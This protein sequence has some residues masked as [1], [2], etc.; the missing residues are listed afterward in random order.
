MDDPGAARLGACGVKILL[1]W[2]SG[3]DSAW[4]LHLLNQQHP[5]AVQGL[6]TTVNESVDRVA[7]HG[8]RRELLE[9]QARAA[10][11]PLLVVGL[12]EPCTNEVYSTRMRGAAGAAAAR[13]FT[14]MAFGDLFLE[15]VRRFREESLAGTGLAAMFP[16]WG[17]PTPQLAREM[18]A[19]G[20][21]AVLSVVDTR[22]L[23]GVLAGREFDQ[24]LLDQLRPGTDPCGERGEFHTFVYAGPMFGQPLAVGLGTA[25]TRDTFVFRDICHIPAESSA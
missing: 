22:A 7:M 5:G 11:L 18:I 12:P 23:D 13:G 9:A 24:A 6:L 10:G 16:L 1:S 3:K 2:S 4:A 20:L 17:A 8:V 14:H 25:V 19:D 15:D 21:R